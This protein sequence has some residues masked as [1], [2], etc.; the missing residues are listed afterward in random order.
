MRPLIL[1]CFIL[2]F[3][4]SLH[5]QMSEEEKA[6]T[7]QQNLAEKDWYNKEMKYYTFGL[8]DE[9]S[10][11]ATQK[12]VLKDYFNIELQHRGCIMEPDLLCY[13]K[14]VEQ[15]VKR[16]LKTDLWQ[17]VQ[18]KADSLKAIQIKRPR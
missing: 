10:G 15:I 11:Q 12:Q 18:H 9:N 2:L 13:N 1:F 17:S 7:R 3:S 14:Q 5:A 4:N 6:C 8:I 16:R